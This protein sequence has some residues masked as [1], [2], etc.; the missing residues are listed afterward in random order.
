MYPGRLPT[1]SAVVFTGAHGKACSKEYVASSGLS[2]GVIVVTCVCGNKT[3]LGFSLLSRKESLS[4][5][6]TIL[7]VYYPWAAIVFYDATW[8]FF[9]SIVNRIPWFVIAKRFLIDV[10][11]KMCHTCGV[12]FCTSTHK[13]TADAHRDPRTSKVESANNQLAGIRKSFLSS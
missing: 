3:A 7:L 6:A 1:L 5:I 2:P 4:I 12:T 9:G 11:H 8:T 10:F 13:S